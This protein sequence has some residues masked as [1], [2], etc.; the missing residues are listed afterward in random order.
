MKHFLSPPLVSGEA[1][2]PLTGAWIETFQRLRI[3]DSNQRRP[4][5]GAWIETVQQGC[6]PCRVASPPHGGVD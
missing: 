2:R 4:L 5:T 3:L 6:L 1:R